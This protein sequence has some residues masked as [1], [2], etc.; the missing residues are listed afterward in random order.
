M[1]A[2]NLLGTSLLPVNQKLR[3]YDVPAVVASDCD[4]LPRSPV[5]PKKAA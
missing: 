1:D 2:V 3:V 5:S 4:R